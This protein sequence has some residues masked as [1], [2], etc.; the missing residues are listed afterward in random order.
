M[1]SA[2]LPAYVSIGIHNDHMG[3]TG[4]ESESDPGFV[5]IT[6]ELRRWVKELEV[7]PGN[8]SARVSR[9]VLGNVIY[10]EFEMAF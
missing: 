8:I 2:T 5:S 4:F 6:G 10:G 9:V 7:I 1:H 3:M